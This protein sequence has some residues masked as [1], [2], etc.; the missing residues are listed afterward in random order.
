MNGG[1]TG[2]DRWPRVLSQGRQPHGCRLHRGACFGSLYFLMEYS[3]F[4][5]GTASENRLPDLIPCAGQAANH[6]S[7]TA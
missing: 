1:M 7:L 4:G 3:A 2:G 5:A 6:S